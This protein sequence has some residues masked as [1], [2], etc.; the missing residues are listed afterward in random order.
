MKLTKRILLGM[1]FLL[2]LG[3]VLSAFQF[4]KV[5]DKSGKGNP[6]FLYGTIL[7]QPF[8]HLVI[9]GGNIPRV[10]YEPADTCSVRVMK[11]WSGFNEKRVK[12]VVQQD[13]LY[14]DFP[15]VYN[16][17]YD[18][19]ALNNSDIL[20]VFSPQLKSVTAFNTNLAMLNVKQQN[21]QLDIS[22]KS[23]FRVESLVKEFDHVSILASDSSDIG[24]Y[25]S[26]VLKYRREVADDKTTVAEEA[27]KGWDVYHVSVLGLNVTGKSTVDVRTALIDSLDAR[28]SDTSSVF[29][30]GEVMKR[31]WR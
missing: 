6:W 1:V 9:R 25:I 28:V 23:S 19:A 18:K 24:V 15:T 22:G 12:A 4:K 27:I 2:F 16:D 20:R 13:T 30:A 26:P 17:V 31:H 10:I 5:Y 7:D 14:I 3:I 29:L 21:L 11:W 8:S